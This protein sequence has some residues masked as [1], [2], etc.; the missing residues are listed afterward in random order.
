MFIPMWIVYSVLGLTMLVLLH[1]RDKLFADNGPFDKWF[2]AW[3]K[4]QEAKM[5]AEYRAKQVTP[6]QNEP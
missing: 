5:V 1:F 4:K 6:H 2:R 3:S